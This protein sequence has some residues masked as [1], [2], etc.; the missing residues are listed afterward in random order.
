MI[1][2]YFVKCA[3]Y[4][5]R[6]L[7][8]DVGRFKSAEGLFDPQLWGADFPSLTQLVRQAVQACP[9]DIRREMWR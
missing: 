3:A 1:K 2:V 9:M 7:T 5:A 6:H 8:N 4:V